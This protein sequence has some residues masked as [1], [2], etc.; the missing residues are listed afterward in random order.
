MN[1]QIGQLSLHPPYIGDSRQLVAHLGN[2]LRDIS[3]LLG[4]GDVAGL[5][6]ALSLSQAYVLCVDYGPESFQFLHF[7]Q[8]E[9]NTGKWLELDEEQSPVQVRD[10]RAHE[11]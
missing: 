6:A 9:R 7:L 5:D 8:G 2:V 1:Q 3:A 11:L 10:G 4:R